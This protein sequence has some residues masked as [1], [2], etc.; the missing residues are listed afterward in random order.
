MRTLRRPDPRDDRLCGRRGASILGRM[1]SLTLAL[2][3]LLTPALRAQDPP[4]PP[5]GFTGVESLDPLVTW[6]VGYRTPMAL[7]PPG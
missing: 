2:A 4:P 6:S 7:S 3:S 5:G 1:R